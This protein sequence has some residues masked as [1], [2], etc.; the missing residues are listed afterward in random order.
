MSLLHPLALITMAKS[1]MF[2]KVVHDC[3]HA[4]HGQCSHHLLQTKRGVQLHGS[5]HKLQNMSCC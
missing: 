5:Y 3:K 2:Q 1:A 4:T